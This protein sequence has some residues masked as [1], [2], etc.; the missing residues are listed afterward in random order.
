MVK[1]SK[2]FYL[3]LLLFI[4]PLICYSENT[5]KISEILKRSTVYIS[6]VDKDGNEYGMG[7]GTV[8]N[9]VKNKFFILTNSHVT[10]FHEKKGRNLEQID[11]REAGFDIWIWPHDS[12]CYPESCMGWTITDQ[13]YWDSNE[14]SDYAILMIDFDLILGEEIEIIDYETNQITYEKIV[15]NDMPDLIPIKIG[16]I[17]AMKELDTIYSAGYPLIV[18]NNVEH[19]KDIFITKGE[20][21]AFITS[22]EGVETLGYYSIVY[23]LG[24]KGG[25]SGGPVVN[26]KGE[27]IAINGLTEMAYSVQQTLHPGTKVYQDQIIP[28]A[29]KYDFG[30][31]IDDIIYSSMIDTEF[32]LNRNSDFYNYLP[33]KAIPSET[34]KL[35]KKE[36][37]SIR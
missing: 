18:G 10:T 23:R 14:G 2:F 30:I 20:I 6:I 36:I 31:S 4:A 32:N 5:R 15:K 22:D 1:Y 34:F 26:K 16:N 37:N 21:N 28:E 29:S 33:K 9:K 25:M 19:Y 13:I 35:L 3:I 24:V 17:N 12:N 8:I 27:L 11:F 7:S